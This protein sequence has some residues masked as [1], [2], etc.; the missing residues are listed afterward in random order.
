MTHHVTWYVSGVEIVLRVD[1]NTQ[2]SFP[3][4]TF[5][6]CRDL[7]NAPLYLGGVK[8]RNS[9]IVS[10]H[11]SASYRFSVNDEKGTSKNRLF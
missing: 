4:N 11:Y 7:F 8:G 10:F 3:F 9:F 6:P 1:R 2:E 5:T